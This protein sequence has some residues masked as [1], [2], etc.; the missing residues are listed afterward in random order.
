[1]SGVGIIDPA[2]LAGQLDRLE[3]I[4]KA[5]LRFVVQALYDYRAIAHDVFVQES[6]AVADIGEDITREALDR[7]GMSRID[8]R[9]FGKVDYKR[10][11]YL[12]QPES[13]VKQALF[14]D[15]KAEKAGKTVMRLQVGQTSLRIRQIRQGERLDV[16][17]T[18]PTI[19]E[20]KNQRFIT[21]T[22]VVKYNY[23]GG[24]AGEE[25]DNNGEGNENAAAPEG[26]GAA[27]PVVG[28]VKDPESITIVALPNG[29]LQEKY[30]PN[31]DD[32]IWNVGPNAPGAGRRISNAVEYS[33]AGPE[34]GMACAA[35]SDGSGCFHVAGLTSP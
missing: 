10:A 22:M 34:S 2:D 5:S 1:M 32:G 13:A 21:T 3:Q 23:V 12:F 26:A 30:N 14:V 17:G 4:E 16:P 28:A 33:Q 29:F 6:D 20:I 35:D 9:L 27:V 8:Q 25:A 19:L 7:V 24:L 11:T 31:A 15:S 18:I